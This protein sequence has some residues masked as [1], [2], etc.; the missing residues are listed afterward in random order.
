MPC[1]QATLY[2]HDH[3]EHALPAKINTEVSD[4]DLGRALFAEN[5][6]VVAEGVLQHSG[7]FK[8]RALGFPPVELR[9][10]SRAAAKVGNLPAPAAGTACMQGLHC[11][12]HHSDTL[13]QAFLQRRRLTSLAGSRRHRTRQLSWRRS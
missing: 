7:T 3:E 12:Q 10:E 9:G 4:Y 13:T 5:C 2:R 8:V 1:E 11:R 6:I